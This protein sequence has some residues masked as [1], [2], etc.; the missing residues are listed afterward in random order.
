MPY[1][2]REPDPDATCCLPQ[3][4]PPPLPPPP[5]EQPGNMSEQKEIREVH[6][7]MGLMEEFLA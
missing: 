6:V 1:V 3:P 5:D 7:S 4:A 2:A